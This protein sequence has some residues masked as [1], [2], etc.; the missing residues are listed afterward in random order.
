MVMPILADLHELN[1]TLEVIDDRLIPFASPPLDGNVIFSARGYD[2]EGCVCS[3]DFVDLKWSKG[4]SAA[5][6][7]PRGSS[8]RRENIGA[9]VFRPLCL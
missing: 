1:A 7:W 3:G 6:A 9:Y 8:P 2:P 5:A 4:R